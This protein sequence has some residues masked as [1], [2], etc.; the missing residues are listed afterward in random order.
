[1]LPFFVAGRYRLPL[2][3]PMIVLAAVGVAW[4]GDAVRRRG[5]RVFLVAGP[6]LG[7]VAVS[8]GANLE[9][10]LVLIA[11]LILGALASER[12]RPL[13]ERAP[14]HRRTA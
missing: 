7:A 13:E 8:F 12:L 3:P 6:G 2:V 10:V 5:Q 9:Q 1:M 14:S 11:A 4:L